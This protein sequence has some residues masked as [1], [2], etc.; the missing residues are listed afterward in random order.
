MTFFR[1]SYTFS[2][3]IMNKSKEPLIFTLDCN[4]SSNMAFSE[5]AGKVTQYIKPGEFVFLM[6]VEALEGFDDFALGA[7]VQWEQA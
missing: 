7:K 2:Y 4:E 1:L 6:H 3:G 5:P